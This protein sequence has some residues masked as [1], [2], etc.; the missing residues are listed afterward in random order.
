MT[1]DAQDL[2]IRI[3]VCDFCGTHGPVSPSP[4]TGSPVCTL[5][6]RTEW[7]VEMKLDE[8]KGA[9]HSSRD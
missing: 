6:R 3:G 5:C 1:V 2:A 9:D 8:H 4:Y 7:V